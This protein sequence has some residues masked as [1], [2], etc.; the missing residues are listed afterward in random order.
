ME[1]NQVVDVRVVKTE[2]DYTETIKLS[3]IGG[4]ATVI[5]TSAT[6]WAMAKLAEKV[7]SR[8]ERKNAAENQN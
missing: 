1:E 8:R 3:I 2:S 4:V 5:A 7:K 6:T